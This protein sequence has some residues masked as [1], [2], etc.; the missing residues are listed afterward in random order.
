M[1]W[2]IYL[3]TIAATTFLARF[4]AGL[5][6][7]PIKTAFYLRRESLA[8]VASFRN[9]SL[10]RPRELA[11]TSQEIRDYDRAIQNL[12]N[13]QHIF[14]D[15]GARFLAFSESEPTISNLMMMFGLDTERAGEEL[16]GL[17]QVYATTRIDTSEGRYEIEEALRSTNIALRVSRCHSGDELTRI[18]LEPI[19]LRD[20]A[21]LY[22]RRNKQ[23]VGKPHDASAGLRHAHGHRHV[24][25]PASRRVVTS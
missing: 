14:A 1:Q 5:L 16:I 24:R 4:A 21:P 13:A 12:R 23:A 15:L 6:S 3:V 9:M 7:G 17:S 20:A 2:Y 10:P 18:R 22:R 8:R 19:Y 11:I 25:Q